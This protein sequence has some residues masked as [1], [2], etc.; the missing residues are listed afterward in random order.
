MKAMGAARPSAATSTETSAENAPSETLRFVAALA[1]A[2][3]HE[4]NNPLT[5]LVGNLELL[6]RTQPL[7]VDGRARMGVALAAA[8]Q[9]KEK[10]RR[11]GRITRLEL[12][13][14]WPNLPPMLDLEKSSV[15]S[16]SGGEFFVTHPTTSDRVEAPR[17]VR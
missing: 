4:I 10:I 2:A 17:N 3:G 5:I 12:A 15:E 13:V 14:G 9:I 8:A 16:T 11:L 1:A 7:D 6:E